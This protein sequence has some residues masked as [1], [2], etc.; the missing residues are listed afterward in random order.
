[1]EVAKDKVWPNMEEEVP[2]WSLY[3]DDST[4]LEKVGGEARD[5][6]VRPKPAGARSA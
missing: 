4:L 6:V 3:L 1:M 5:A 2:A